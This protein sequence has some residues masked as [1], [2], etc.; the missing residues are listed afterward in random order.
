MAKII[1]I[2]EL[3]AKLDA[4]ENFYL[5]DARSG[6]DFEHNH[7]PEAIG[8][9][10][11]PDFEKSLPHILPDKDSEIIVY[12]TNESCVMAKGAAD[13]LEK[14]GYARVGLFS[15]GMVAWME[16]GYALEFGRAS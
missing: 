15:G 9:A 6:E 13:F 5:I 14:A 3:R 1:K 4:E 2:D 8:L 10:W 12:G 16:A 7:L 11:G